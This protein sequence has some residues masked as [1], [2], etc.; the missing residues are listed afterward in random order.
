MFYF[1]D[2]SNGY[3]IMELELQLTATTVPWSEVYLLQQMKICLLINVQDI[4]AGGNV[5]PQHTSISRLRPVLQ[6]H[7]QRVQFDP[8][9]KSSFRTQ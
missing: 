7:V 8:V 6:V 5:E 2:T 4:E 3:G 1:D 9:K